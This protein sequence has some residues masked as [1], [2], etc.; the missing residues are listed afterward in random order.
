METTTWTYSHSQI[1]KYRTCPR[2]YHDEYMLGIKG[3]KTPNMAFGTWMLH[4]PIEEYLRQQPHFTGL[5]GAWWETVWANYLAEFGG[6]NDF[7]DPI[8]NMKTARK[9]LD[10]YKKSPIEGEVKA[11]EGRNY[12]TFPDGLRYVS[13]P[14]FVVEQNLASRYTVDLKFTTGWRVAPLLP[15]DDQCLGQ[16][17]VAGADGFIRMTFQGD[18]KTGKVSGP[19]TEEH[20]VD[21]MLREEWIEETWATCREIDSWRRKTYATWPKDDDTCFRY[22]IDRPCHRI[23]ACK[24]GA[25]KHKA[26]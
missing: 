18:K 5:T 26:L 1:S 3:P 7:D 2:L 16:A 11:V 19:Y 17:I 20:A 8:L 24:S 10:L 22:G 25:V 13:V 4:E 12:Y 23:A 15:Y 14:D 6:D 9:C 21:P